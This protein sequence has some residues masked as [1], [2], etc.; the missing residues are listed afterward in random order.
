[1]FNSKVENMSDL[2]GLRKKWGFKAGCSSDRIGCLVSW[3]HGDCTG[4]YP[5]KKKRQTII[6]S[7]SLTTHGCWWCCFVSR[8]VEAFFIHG[9]NMT[10]K[11]K[12]CI[13]AGDRRWHAVMQQQFEM[14]GKWKQQ[15]TAAEDSTCRYLNIAVLKPAIRFFLEW[16]TLLQISS[17]SNC[18]HRCHQHWIATFFLI[19][20]THC[21]W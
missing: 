8:Y 5:P 4:Y 13:F 14:R 19:V 20:G 1:M 7:V 15:G 2:W 11:C 10:E 3:S 18:G 16:D 12:K 21:R 17:S 9:R 6:K